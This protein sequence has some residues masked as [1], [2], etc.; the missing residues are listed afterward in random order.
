MVD[1]ELRCQLTDKEQAAPRAAVFLRVLNQR[2]A[3]AA[4]P[5]L[6][7]DEVV[8]QVEPDGELPARRDAVEQGVG[9]QL[10]DAELYVLDQSRELPLGE[11][12]DDEIA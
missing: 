1:P 10:R 7:P 9:R 4:V 6:Q 8:G 12:I 11:D 5:D 2:L 3:I